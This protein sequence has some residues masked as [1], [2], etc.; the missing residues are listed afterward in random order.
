[1]RRD[2]MS[3]IDNPRKVSGWVLRIERALMLGVR[4]RVYAFAVIAVLAIV[5]ASV[6]VS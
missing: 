3:I 5:S 6:L 4:K 2:V 1:M